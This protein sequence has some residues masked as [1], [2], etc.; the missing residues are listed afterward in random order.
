MRDSQAGERN[1][2]KSDAGARFELEKS[3]RYLVFS[4]D[5]GDHMSS[6]Q[7]I[8]RHIAREHPVTWVNTIG[9]RNPKLTLRDARKAWRKLSRMCSRGAAR[10]K[11]PT[12][13]APRVK[14]C[15]PFMLPFAA[16]R[17]VRAFNVASV[18]RAL[19][20]EIGDLDRRTVVVTTVPNAGDY[21]ELLR[22]A[23]VVYYCVDDFAL[24]PGHQA[25]LVRDMEQ[26]LIARADV[27]VAASPKL[28]ERL[29][30]SGK[31][32]VLLTHGVDVDLF[33]QPRTAHARLAG[34]PKPRAGFFGLIDARLD[35]R[36]IAEVAE[37]M[38]DF[39][40]VLSGPIELQLETLAR[41]P[42]V[43]FTGPIPYR[44]L[45]S[46]V[47]ALDVLFIPYSVGELGDTLSPLKLKE[48]LVTGKPIV[49][50]P[51]SEARL[52][53]PHVVTAA[54][55]EEWIR[56][57]RSALTEDPDTRRRAILPAM[58][59]ESWAAKARTLLGVCAS[60]ALT[61]LEPASAGQRQGPEAAPTIG[62]READ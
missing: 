47:A 60:A 28:Y 3:L 6:S 36:L 55:P 35:E 20:R 1:R 43:H 45:P 4:D 16:R 15:Q 25:E 2:M 12:D 42:N 31:P 54:S 46:L 11:P 62:K 21:A 32:T 38:P 30:A 27:L 52:R 39:S 40:F 24:W 14:V 50:T 29:A 56:A 58:E 48:Y 5:W 57:L 13:H 7:H 59:A 34:I 10:P 41:Q 37:R 49:S 51:I 33:T 9:M 26:R 8:F 23:T 17:V 61:P 22:H 18:T 44:E 19:R 53:A